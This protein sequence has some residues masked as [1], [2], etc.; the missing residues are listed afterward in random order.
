MAK[1]KV[2]V[3]DDSA[4]MRK[5]IT[6]MVQS[7]SQ[8]EVIG[9]AR[10][11]KDALTKL[12]LLQPDVITLD[13]EMPEMDGLETL[14]RIQKD[15]SKPVIML[16]STTTA[17]AENTLIA[18]EN[19]AFDFVSKPSG[20]I[21]LDLHIVKDELNQKIKLAH[22]Y[23]QAREK[24]G[25]ARGLRPQTDKKS[26]TK[27]TF[28]STKPQFRTNV[29]SQAPIES[30]EHNRIKKSSTDTLSSIILIGTSTGGP[31][32]LQQLLTNLPK[33]DETA[34]LIVQHMPPGFTKSLANRLDKQSVHDVKEAEQGEKLESGKVYIAPGGY[35]M[36]LNQNNLNHHISISLNQE[37]PIGGHRPSVDALFESAMDLKRT[38]LMTI[39]MTGMGKDGMNG[40]KKLSTKQEVYT[41]A[42]DES[43]CVVY[44]MPRAVVEA[45]LAHEVLP[46]HEIHLA[47][48]K[49]LNR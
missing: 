7:D 30:S 35:H 42:E 18:L 45:Q 8:L 28:I 13:V 46:L 27:S 10:N 32:A 40:L 44:G 16:S 14:Q 39:V 29:E 36:C 33:L 38:S 24:Q 31:K 15:M 23:Q 17:G 48:E 19:G 4:F 22:L 34:V 49:W 9:T 26:P 12:K 6:D 41:V 11:G 21:S 3:V 37:P 5:I 1:I 2:F 20:S 25:T 47:I 43:T